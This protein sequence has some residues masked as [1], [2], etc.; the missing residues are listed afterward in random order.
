MTYPQLLEITAHWSAI[1]TAA[2]ATCFSLSYWCA[3]RKKRLALEAHLKCE[4]DKAK[5]KGQR[6]LIHLTRHLSM[7][8]AD[9]L[10]AAFSSKKVVAKARVND[11][12]GFAEELLFVHV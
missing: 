10:Q 6:T 11:T 7:T 9:I 5:D 12:T 1:L 2:V 3:R 4:K 8:E